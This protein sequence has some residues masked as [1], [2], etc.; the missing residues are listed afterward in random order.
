ML[1]RKTIHVRFDG[2]CEE[3]IGSG[4]DKSTKYECYDFST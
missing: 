2:F 4:Y 1:T 3:S